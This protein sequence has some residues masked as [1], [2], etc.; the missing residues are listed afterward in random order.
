M[1]KLI[2]IVLVIS[3]LACLFAG[4]GKKKPAEQGGDTTLALVVA[5]TFGDRSFYDS[6]KQ[7]VDRLA[8]D[9]G[10]K[11]TTIEC[12]NENHTPQMRNAAD[13]IVDQIEK[14]LKK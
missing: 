5:G 6:S 9:L 10:I 4:C 12:N 3:L 14:I 11:V 13:K 8:K 7:G 1:K 2:A